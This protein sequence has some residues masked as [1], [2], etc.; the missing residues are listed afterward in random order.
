MTKTKLMAMLL[1][2]GVALGAWSETVTV[3]SGTADGVP[4]QEG[5]SFL[6]PAGGHVLLDGKMTIMT[7]TTERI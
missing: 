4:V 7:T 2:A 6:I 1:A 5:S 3:G